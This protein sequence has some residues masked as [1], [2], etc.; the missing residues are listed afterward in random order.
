MKTLLSVLFSTIFILN[1]INIVKAEEDIYTLYDI[2]QDVIIEQSSSFNEIETSFNNYVVDENLDLIVKENEKIILMEYGVVSFPTGD[3]T[4]TVNYEFTNLKTSQGAYVNGCY[5]NDA[6]YL[7]TTS[8]GT[9]VEFLISG[10]YGSGDISSVELIPYAYLKSVTSYIVINKELFHQVK[11]NVES[12][13]F[14]TLISLGEAPNYLVE[15]Q[16]YYSYDGHYFYDDFIKMSDD[17]SDETVV[18][19]LNFS[20]PFYFYYQYVSHRSMTNITYSML[21]DYLRNDLKIESSL[22]YYEDQHKDSVDDKLTTS[23]YLG[24]EAS[25]FQYQN[26]FGSNAMMMFA[27]SMN[28]SAFGRSSLAYTRNNL[29]GH[30]AYDSDV[31]KYASRYLNVSNSVYSHAKNYIS[32]SYLNP[33]SFTYHGGYFGDKASGLNVSYASD[34]YWGE[35]AAQFYADIDKEF[36]SIDLNQYALGIKSSSESI[37]IYDSSNNIISHSG[38]NPHMSFIILEETNNLY[39]IQ[40]DEIIYTNN[41]ISGSYDFENNVGY[42]NKTDIDVILNSEQIQNDDEFITVTFNANGGEFYGEV[43]ILTYK[44]RKGDELVS[45]EPVKDGALF[46]NWDQAVDS[47]N[48]DTTFNAIYQEV[49]SIEFINTPPNIVEYNDRIVIGDGSIKVNYADGTNEEVLI[50]TSMISNYNL[51]E[52]G[53]Y[54]VLVTYAGHTISYPLEVVMELDTIRNE[55]DELIDETIINY[56][57]IEEFDIGDF[58]TLL[59]MQGKFKDYLTPYI[60]FNEIRA[61]D[62]VYQSAFNEYVDTSIKDNDVNLQLSGLYYNTYIE[63]ILDDKF[64]N[65]LIELEYSTSVNKDISAELSDIALAN[66]YEISHVFSVDGKLNGDDIEIIDDIL[67]SIDIP[68]DL[69][70]N[71]IITVIGYNDGEIKKLSTIQTKNKVVFKTSEFTEFILV[72]QNT[73]NYYLNE[74]IIENTTVDNNVTSIVGYIV[75]GLILIISILLIIMVIVINNYKKGA[76]K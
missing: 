52:V 38:K 23:Q 64:F 2:N 4:C 72:Y 37:P 29:F 76:K 43:S 10:A 65:D 70:N 27:L 51:L 46:I 48:Q 35:K 30:A 74:D 17:V 58:N 16:I 73:T 62:K 32:L 57:N 59:Y 63:N 21:Y 54:D 42:I 11:S 56:E 15:N 20:E 41:T 67:I 1:S 40:L 49:D 31:E 39:K 50:T 7:N 8:N 12:D 53:N 5:G 25:F 18:N 71:N 14:A 47:I 36:N 13:K 19:S 33:N 28:E 75:L 44:I 69:S 68:K 66:N 60:T 34:P 6:L 61:L 22:N 55:L 26:L 24:H 3:G 9:R 45:V